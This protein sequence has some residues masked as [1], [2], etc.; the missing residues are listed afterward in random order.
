MLRYIRKET[1]SVP[2]EIKHVIFTPPLIMQIGIIIGNHYYCVKDIVRYYH[3]AY[4]DSVVIF[5]ISGLV[6]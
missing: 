1:P 3:I 4:M 2:G 6:P 5:C